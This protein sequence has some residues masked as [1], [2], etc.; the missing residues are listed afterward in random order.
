MRSVQDFRGVRGSTETATL[1]DPNGPMWMQYCQS[2]LV[3]RTLL[4]GQANSLYVRRAY[5]NNYGLMERLESHRFVSSGREEVG[6]C[7]D[8]NKLAIWK[9]HLVAP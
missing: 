1:T 6:G 5:V 7:K 8:Q 2:S 4:P 3:V 9:T